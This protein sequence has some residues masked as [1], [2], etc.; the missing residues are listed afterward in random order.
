MKLNEKIN[1]LLDNEV[2]EVEGWNFVEG[3]NRLVI[4]DSCIRKMGRIKNR[5]DNNKM[6]LNINSILTRDA[7]NNQWVIIING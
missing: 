6:L 2:S 3:H 1:K 4:N 5:L 7:H